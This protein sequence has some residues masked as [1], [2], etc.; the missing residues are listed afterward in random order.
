MYRPYASAAASSTTF[1]DADATIRGLTQDLATAFNTG[2]FD[3]ASA[4]FA[5]E[6]MLMPPN[7]EQSQG[8]KAVEHALRDLSESGVQDLRLETIRIEHSGDTAVEIGRYT[9]GVSQPNGTTL[10]ERGKYVRAW[11]RLGAW[12]IIADC[13]N[14][15]LPAPK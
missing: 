2:N 5:P 3:Q 9:A 8:T 12:R 15:S 13:W 1:L 11:R 10:A 4:L 7:R 6:G 14:S